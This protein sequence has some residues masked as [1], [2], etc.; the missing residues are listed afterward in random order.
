MRRYR[1]S[2]N[3]SIFFSGVPLHVQQ[4]ALRPYFESVGRVFEFRLMGPSPG[5]DFRY[6]EVEY[7]DEKTAQE[8]IERLNGH[9]FG[10]RSMRVALVDSRLKKRGRR[11]VTTRAAGTDSNGKPLLQFSR[12][13]FDPVLGREESMVLDVLKNTSVED[14]YEA[15]EQLRV[16]A[17][18]RPDDAR[19]LL[20]ENPAL[21]SA[22]IMI[23]QH[24]RRIPFGPLPPEAFE[25]TAELP[26]TIA[27][28]EA[29]EEADS[30]V[31]ASGD[32]EKADKHDT[33]SSAPQTS[34]QEKSRSGAQS[35]DFNVTEITAE[36][37]EQ[38]IRSIRQMRPE[39]VEKII[40]LT[41]ADVRR[42][43]NPHQRKQLQ[44]L[45]HCLIEMSKDLE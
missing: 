15:V 20:Q 36:Q 12:G 38:A 35:D 28:G 43:Q 1:F 17:I 21:N 34:P 11:E 41:P 27:S 2:S 14:A 44:L 19:A 29:N 16:L 18:E 39:D 10:D 40:H 24:A 26:G 3:T 30:A 25:S 32:Q 7:A 22:V 5:K 42:V 6:G 23:L 31:S 4:E 33:K 8:A 13:F 45:Q 9:S 37:K